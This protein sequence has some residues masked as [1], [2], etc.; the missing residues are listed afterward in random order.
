MRALTVM[1]NVADLAGAVGAR[2]VAGVMDDNATI[3]V[4]AIHDGDRIVNSELEFNLGEAA[5][6]AER[7]LSGDQ[8]AKTTP[9]LARIL[10]A[11][12]AVLFRVS[13]AAGAF[14]QTEGLDDRDG[15]YLD[16]QFAAGGDEDPGD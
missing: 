8:R 7:I 5:L 11:S 1:V 10:S 9:G 12:V 16:D 4:C 15:G 14:Q 6:L 13:L 2:R 3:G